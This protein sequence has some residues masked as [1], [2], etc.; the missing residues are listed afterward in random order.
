M[1]QRRAMLF[2]LVRTGIILGFMLATVNWARNAGW[3][4]VAF[5]L[6][7]ILVAGLV[8]GTLTV[9]REGAHWSGRFWGYSA[10]SGGLG[11]VLPNWLV[12]MTMARDGVISA[13]VFYLLSPLF[14]QGLTWLLGI[15]RL[16]P[17]RVAGLLLGAVGAAILVLVPMLR[18]SAAEAGVPLLGLLIPL[19]LAA[20]NIY[21]KRYMPEDRSALS[22]AAGMLLASGL[23]FVPL[24]LMALLFEWRGTQV[25]SLEPLGVQ[26]L[27]MGLGFVSYFQFLRRVDPVYFSQLGYLITLTGGLAGIIF[28]DE[29]PG[30][31]HGASLTLVAWGVWLVTR[32]GRGPRNRAVEARS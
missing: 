21:R 6:A 5:T 28:F 11:M 26:A 15:D 8:L 18:D 25:G 22:L 14:T 24:Y 31:H 13:A 17:V 19:S 16:V 3:G 32:Q 30:W 4:S 10:I 20:G 12:F 9:V 23:L 2:L 1:S 29:A 7:P 27:I